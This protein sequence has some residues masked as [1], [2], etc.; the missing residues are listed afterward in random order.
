[1]ANVLVQEQLIQE[2][3]DID[4]SYIQSLTNLTIQQEEDSDSYRPGINEGVVGEDDHD[5]QDIY[6]W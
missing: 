6:D 4:A 5:Y 1:M 2:Q 3:E